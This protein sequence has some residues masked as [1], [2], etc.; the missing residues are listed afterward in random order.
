MIKNC[1]NLLGLGLLSLLFSCNAT[2]KTIPYAQ[3]AD[4]G[5]KLPFIKEYKAGQK[6]ILV[7]GSYHTNDTTDTEIKDIEYSLTT[8]KPEI[9]LYEGDYIGVE[10]TK[11]ESISNYFEMGLVRW[12]A[13]R[14]GVKELNLEPAAR[15]RYHH[16]QKKF[17]NDYILLATV[18]GQNILYIKQ[19]SKDEFDKFYPSVISDFEKEGFALTEKQKQLSHFYETYQTFY[20]KPFEPTTFD[21][22]TVEPKFNKTVLNKINQESASFRDQFMLKKIDSCLKFHSKIYVQVG[23]RHAI[24]W[25]PALHK[26]VAKN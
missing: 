6:A 19:H 12:W 17:N 23:G 11:Q 5:I 3:S 8:F 9:I 4:L 24:V 21:Y 25:Q 14:Y 18:L 20:K 15:E 2:Y 13:Q 7:Y 1:I 10:P 22:E 26:I 16:L